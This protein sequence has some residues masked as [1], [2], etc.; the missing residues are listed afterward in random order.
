M[1][2]L[3]GLITMVR[4]SS[5]IVS[6]EIACFTFTG[7]QYDKDGIQRMWW[8]QTAVNAFTERTKCF[9]NQYSMYEMFGISVSVHVANDP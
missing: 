9:V 6:V 7:R 1:N 4:H 5:L 2:L 3:T 8:T